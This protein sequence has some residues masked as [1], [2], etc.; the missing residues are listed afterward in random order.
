MTKIRCLVTECDVVAGKIYDA[1]I[2]ESSKTAIFTDDINE[3]YY[4]WE[5]Q[6]EL[7]PDQQPEPAQ[8]D[9]MATGNDGEYI[10]F[11]NRVKA[12]F[13]VVTGAR[14]CNGKYFKL[15]DFSGNIIVNCKDEKTDAWAKMV[16]HTW[17]LEVK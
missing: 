3:E 1:T 4:L 11:D 2:M 7:L 17:P 15:I 9:W 5:S 12:C 8:S 13:S 14:E 6:Y 10:C 16:G